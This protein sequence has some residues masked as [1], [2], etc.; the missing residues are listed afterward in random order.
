MLPIRYASSLSEAG[1][2]PFVIVDGAPVAPSE[3]RDV[4][5]HLA[6]WPGNTTPAALKRDLSTEIAFAFIDLP[7]VER[8]EMLRDKRAYV[9]NHF[10]TDGICALFVLTRPDSARVHRGL[11]DQVAASG[12]F[13]R[14][15]SD[16]AFAID[17][18]IEGLE[19]AGVRRVEC[20]LDLLGEL[21]ED[22]A[23]AIARSE[24]EVE[25]L[26][27]DRE[28]LERASFDDLVYLDFGVWTG[29]EGFDPGRH[30]FFGDGRRDRAL[31]LGEGPAGTTARFVIGTRSFFDM[32]SK[33]PSAR[34]DLAEL[35]T[36]LQRL[37]PRAAGEARW[38]H[39]A[40]K[41]ATPELWFGTEGLPLYAEHAGSVLRPSGIPTLE[42]KRV[43]L[44]AIRTSWELP[45]DDDEAESGEDIFAV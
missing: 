38:H 15:D 22:E 35:A 11:L 6:H 28:A 16:H 37:E 34:P 24:K 10:D 32:V 5:L 8:V 45:D 27:R 17:A 9:L 19:G 36:A 20:A 2:G 41:T 18:A 44:E 42:I 23:R 29:A 21:L 12:D 3:I 1:E 33:R 31:L 7:E 25:R 30:A 14:V 40:Q 43:V 39:H 26:A 4:D 13:F